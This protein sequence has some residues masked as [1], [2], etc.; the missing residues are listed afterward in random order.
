MRIEPEHLEVLASTDSKK[1]FAYF[2][3]EIY[4]FI[5]YA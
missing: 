1:A 5:S 2:K 3:N 4:W